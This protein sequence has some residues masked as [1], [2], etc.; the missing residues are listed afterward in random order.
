MGRSVVFHVAAPAALRTP[1]PSS[2]V[3]L[4]KTTVPL[5]TPVP[6]AGVTVAT[7]ATFAPFV[8][9]AGDAVTVVTVEVDVVPFAT[10]SAP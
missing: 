4:E 10:C 5:G 8:T 7:K 6:K 1:L 2:A 3:P 9:L